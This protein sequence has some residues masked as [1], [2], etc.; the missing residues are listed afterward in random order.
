[1]QS[2]HS[3]SRNQRSL[4][5]ESEIAYTQV[6][7][8]RIR[9]TVLPRPRLMTL[10]SEITDFPV[11]VVKAGAG[12][13]K[14]TSLADWIL[15]SKCTAYWL[16]I[17]SEHQDAV[18]FVETLAG[19][20]HS[21]AIPAREWQHVIEGTHA[22]AT[23]AS[24]ANLASD[25][26]NTYCAEETI[27]VLDDFHVLDGSSSTL[28]WVDAWMRRL[29]PNVHIVI[30]TRTNPFLAYV[31]SLSL[32]GD[33]LWVRE[34]ELSFTEV[35]VGVLFREGARDAGASSELAASQVRWLLSKSAGMAMVLAVLLREWRQ[36]PLFS[37]LQQLLVEGTSIQDQIG[38]L[39]VQNLSHQQNEFL[40]KTSLFST[41]HPELCNQALGISISGQVLAELERGGHIS[42][43]DGGVYQL[44]PL[45][46]EYLAK[47]LDATIRQTLLECAVN[48]HL[49][50]G[51][52][53]QAIPYLFLMDNEDVLI[54]A[55]FQYIPRYLARGQVS[56]VQGWLDKLPERIVKDSAGLLYT[57]AEVYRHTNDFGEALYS[58]QRAE[59]RAK[60]SRDLSVLVQVEMGRARLYLDTIQPGRALPHIKAA[61]RYAK[62]QDLQ[63]RY[64]ILQLDFENCINLGRIG[65]AKRMMQL[66]TTLHGA[67]LPGNNSDLRLL[68][69]TGSITEVINLLRQR[70]S[71]DSADERSAL[72]HREAS[73]LLALMYAMSGDGERAKEQALRGHWIGHSLQSPFVSAVGL[74]RLGHAEH[75]LNP[76]GDSA[77]TAYQAAI[78]RMEE[79]AIPRGKSEALLGLCLAHGYRGQM[80]LAKS[81]ADAGIEYAMQVEDRWMASLARLA[82]GQCAVVN[83]VTN[84]A[85]SELSQCEQD[86]IAV[87]DEFL[88]AASRLWRGLVLYQ[89]DDGQFVSDFDLVFDAAVRNHFLFLLERPTLCGVRDIQ[90]LVPVLQ[91]YVKRGHRKELALQLLTA[92]SAV[93]LEHH[94]GYSLKVQTLGPFRVWRGFTEVTR[95]EWQREK[96]RQLFQFLVTHR[97]QLFHREEI[98]ALLW[99]DSDSDSAER[100]FKVAL[101]AMSSVLEP[102]RKRGPSVYIVRTGGMYG[103]TAD[104]LAVVDRDEFQSRIA[105][106]ESAIDEDR[107]RLL[108]AS[109]LTLYQGDYLTD[110]RYETWCESERQRMR[111]MMVRAAVSYAKICFA[112]Q[113]YD[114]AI[115]ACERALAVE[116]AWEDAYVLLM[117]IYGAQFNRSMVISTYHQCERVLQRELGVQPL[118]TTIQVYNESVNLLRKSEEWDAAS[119][120][121]R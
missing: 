44:H 84:L 23:L 115:G 72:A 114:E 22:P 17:G 105:E 8:P 106:A 37:R 83:G 71:L 70:V 55:L 107:K 69:R 102:Y 74:I 87:G 25:L 81:Y 88:L 29:P 6:A 5:R 40:R 48:W 57:R 38:R 111:M 100:D 51:E 11:V 96:A 90:S 110:V 109:A 42:L 60:E 99:G 97:G 79:M 76:L 49:S 31:E 113:R 19:T 66:L 119:Q 117:Q 58:Y 121:R 92:I 63:T 94:P 118:P 98:C 86:F 21:L 4:N 28:G 103:F 41:L 36:Q 93:T 61:R 54:G 116:P 68:L 20:L 64:A 108:Y 89:M 62:R 9:S 12:Y 80:A 59:E 16:T 18:H 77:L 27:I 33:V 95:R 1:M 14:T 91:S 75:L 3:G 7:V 120:H 35:E 34:R 26:L 104:S 30:A 53:A 32:R 101:H 24:S 82:L 10:L 15:Q 112:Q 78:N 2:A 39:F 13:G 45:V 85:V 65:R 56:T 43:T 67:S 73:L 46:R 50:R 52:E 47:E